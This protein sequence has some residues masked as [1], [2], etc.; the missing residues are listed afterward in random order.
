MRK[1]NKSKVKGLTSFLLLMG[2]RLRRRDLLRR[3]IL[4]MIWWL[5][6]NQLDL[7]GTLVLLIKLEVDGLMVMN[8]FKGFRLMGK[9][10]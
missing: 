10:Q 8:L 3:I 7:I 4:R 2:M 1:F 6:I 9:C 5:N